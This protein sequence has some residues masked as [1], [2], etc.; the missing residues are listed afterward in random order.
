MRLK[1]EF[2]LVRIILSAKVERS[3]RTINDQS[4][5][6][7]STEGQRNKLPVYAKMYN[8][9]M[10]TSVGR[11]CHAYLVAIDSSSLPPIILPTYALICP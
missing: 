7:Y 9:A 10:S 8:A 4:T 5:D 1:F 11:R 3:A 2:T 6:V